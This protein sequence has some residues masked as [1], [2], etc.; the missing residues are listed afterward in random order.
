MAEYGQHTIAGG[1]TSALVTEELNG[2][3]TDLYNRTDDLYN[4]TTNAYISTDVSIDAWRI[5]VWQIAG[6]TNQWIE[7]WYTWK[8]LGTNFS[9]GNAFGGTFTQYTANVVDYP[10]QISFTEIPHETISMEA[11][12]GLFAGTP[13]AI[14]GIIPDRNTK[15]HTARA[16][17]YRPTTGAPSISGKYVYVNFYVSGWGTYSG[18]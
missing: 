18:S 17:F 10:T 14:S 12:F 16:G 1:Q 4:K 13:S 15:T 11:E 3:F 8:V 9:S 7:M 5:R 6:Q 2:M